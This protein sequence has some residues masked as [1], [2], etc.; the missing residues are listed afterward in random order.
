MTDFAHAFQ[1]DHKNIKFLWNEI[2][3]LLVKLSH[4]IAQRDKTF[5]C[6]S[7]NVFA[8]FAFPSPII[9]INPFLHKSNTTSS[10]RKHFF[11][12]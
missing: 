8:K 11:A 10:E 5:L 7:R 2:S 6:A 4:L 1:N 12:N 9:C 3:P